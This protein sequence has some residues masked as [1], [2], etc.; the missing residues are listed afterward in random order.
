M[1]VT[2]LARWLHAAGPVCRGGKVAMYRDL[3]VYACRLIDG[4]DLEG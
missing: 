2:G 4:E 1:R 3:G